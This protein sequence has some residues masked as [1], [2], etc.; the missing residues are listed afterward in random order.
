MHDCSRPP[1]STPGDDLARRLDDIP[2]PVRPPVP[3]PTGPLTAHAPWHGSRV[4]VTGAQ[5]FIGRHLVRRLV[6]LGAAVT[7]TER[8]TGAASPTTRSR[9]DVVPVPARVPRVGCDLGD[10]TATRRRLHSLRPDVVFH[11][12]SRVQGDRRPDLVL[13]MLEDNTRVAVNLMAAAAELVPCRVVLA[14]SVEEAHHGEAP[15]SPYAAAKG[16]ATTY[17]QLFHA[18]WGLAVTV[19]RLAMVYGPDQPDTRKL[20]PY[21]VTRM[22]AGD[23]LQLG[24]GTRRI[25]WIYIDDVCAA[26]LRAAT[27]D[28]APGLVVDIGTGTATSIRDTVTRVATLIGYRNPLI[29]GARSDRLDEREHITDPTVAAELFGW[30]ARTPLMEGLTRTVAWYRSRTKDEPPPHESPPRGRAQPVDEPCLGAAT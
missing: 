28:R 11:L 21:V 12:A 8:T 1:A 22:L 26:L 16:A 2:G 17:A 19:A 10:A 18:Q 20:L 13:P 5:G 23:T 7:I 14:G 6:A 9:R 24:S 4:L 27:A 15:C 29:F 3:T 30:R 25:D